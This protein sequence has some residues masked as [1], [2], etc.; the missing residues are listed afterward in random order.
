MGRLEDIYSC[1]TSPKKYGHEKDY[2]WISGI[3]LVAVGALGLVGNF[4]TLFVLCRQKFRKKIFY[5]LLME[6]ACFDIIFILSY[7]IDIGYQSLF[8]HPYNENVIHITYPFLNLGLSGSIYSTVV[9][10]IERYLG[11]CHPHLKCHRKAW[12]YTVPV[13]IITIS[14]NMPRF[15]ERRYSIVN[16]TLIS[17]LTPRADSDAYHDAY[18]LWAPIVVEDII[19]IMMLLILNGSI[20]AKINV[21]SKQMDGAKNNQQRS[22]K[23]SSTKILFAIVAIFLICH[24][25]SLVFKLLYHLGSED[26]EFREKWYFLAPIKRLALMIN[27]SVN[28]I[29]YCLVGSKIS[30]EVLFVLGIKKMT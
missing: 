16:G 25:P 4:L 18:H 17:T 27:S 21:I 3:A 28:F 23:S 6:M 2:F 24:I 29:I 8:C 9:V 10:S 12:F 7:G 14:Y 30:S 1:L 22:Q 15:L 13:A 26:A 19:P 11:M 20:A 5:Q